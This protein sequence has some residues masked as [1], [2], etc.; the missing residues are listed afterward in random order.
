MSDVSVSH[1]IVHTDFAQAGDEEKEI[2]RLFL[3][4][5]STTSVLLLLVHLA[6]THHAVAV[7]TPL[8]QRTAAG[9]GHL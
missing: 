6:K 7:H 9:G 2:D 4:I 5:F 3:L 8:G 1:L